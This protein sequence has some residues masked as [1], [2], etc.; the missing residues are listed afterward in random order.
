MTNKI[1][2]SNLVRDF[3]HEY[4]KR[5]G[6]F[7]LFDLANANENAN[8]TVLEYLLKFDKSRFLT[9]FLKLARLTAP[10]GTANIIAQKKAIGSQATGYIDL[11]IE[12]DDKCVIVEN[13]LYGATDTEKQLARYVATVCG[14]KAAGFEEWYSLPK[15]NREIIVIYLTADGTKEPTMDS[16][17]QQV[18]NQISYISMNY[19]DDI[20]PWLKGEV[21]PD[22]PYGDDGML[23]AGLRQYIAFLEQLLTTESSNVVNEYVKELK[24]TDREKYKQLLTPIDYNELTVPENV[25]KS[26]RK[27]LEREAEKI[28]NGDMSGEWVL[29]FTP[30]FIVLYKQK[31]AELDIRKY[32]IPTIH[33]NFQNTQTFLNK[34]TCNKLSLVIT[35]LP[36][37]VSH[38]LIHN[39]H[40]RNAE[41]DLTH[42]LQNLTCSDVDNKIVRVAFYGKLIKSIQDEIAKV[43]KLVDSFINGG[44]KAS[45]EEILRTYL[46]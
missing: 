38:N 16:L 26:L 24:G 39:N 8:T 31:W 46:Q 9:S 17:P 19:I 20:L 13:K 6:K 5:H 11:Y 1:T 29:H 18:R 10:G 21:M 33:L 40:D 27:D 28:F 44:K 35:H 45:P 7:L 43:D 34:G 36:S 23:I 2:L 32:S 42:K 37:G 25:Q 3:Y 14:V 15:V 30:S 41:V 4:Q 22:I 12:Y